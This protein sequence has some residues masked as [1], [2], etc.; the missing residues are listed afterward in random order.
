M[1]IILPGRT[2]NPNN[3]ERNSACETKSRKPLRSSELAV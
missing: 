1:E 2:V 3:F